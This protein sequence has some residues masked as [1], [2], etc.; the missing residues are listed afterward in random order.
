MFR[1]AIALICFVVMVAVS[2]MSPARADQIELSPDSVIGG[3]GSWNNPQPNDW[4]VGQFAAIYVADNQFEDEI[5]EP[6]QSGEDDNGGFWLGKEG[7]EEESFVLDLGQS[8]TIDEIQLYNTH[9]AT[10]DDR[11]TFGYEIYGSNEVT[12][13]EV[14]DDELGVGGD[15]LIDPQ[16]MSEGELELVYFDEDPIPPQ[17]API[18]NSGPFRYLRF[19]TLGPFHEDDIV[20][21][22]RSVGINEIKVFGSPG[23][24][25]PFDYNGDGELGIGDVDLLS[26]EIQAGTNREEFDVTG[27]NLVDAADLQEYIES[28][29]ILNSYLGDAN[30]DGEFNSSDFVETFGAGLYET[31]NPATWGQGDWNADGRFD[32]SDFVTAFAGGGYELGPKAAQAAVPEPTSIALVLVALLTLGRW[33]NGQV[34]N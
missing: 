3:T 25:N 20:L 17:A 6:D 34:A 18:A 12:D 32:S 23:G 1:Y 9:N 27:D 2:S 26:E 29:T 30:L 19:S 21:A 14:V 10:F 24:G 33:R 22:Q 11:A 16:L 13:F 7:D 4:D 28:P 15:D 5:E 8:Y 31:G